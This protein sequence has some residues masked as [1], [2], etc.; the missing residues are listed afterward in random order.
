MDNAH[1]H[2]NADTALRPFGIRNATQ[3]SVQPTGEL[4][5]F[6]KNIFARS[7]VERMHFFLCIFRVASLAYAR[8]RVCVMWG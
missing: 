8:A 2:T 5:Q 7:Y 1:T 6:F 4:L 3:V